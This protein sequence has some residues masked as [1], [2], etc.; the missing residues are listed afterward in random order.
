MHSIN[1]LMNTLGLVSTRAKRRLLLK[2]FVIEAALARLERP[3][4][5]E[6]QTIVL[7]AVGDRMKVRWPDW[8]TVR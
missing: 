4:S 2:P 8:W 3:L 1:Y 5:L 7:R 6:E